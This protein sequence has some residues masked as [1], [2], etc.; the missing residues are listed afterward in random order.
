VDHGTAYDL[1]GTGRASALS[2]AA[3]IR[4]AV[5]MAKTAHGK[6]STKTKNQRSKKTKNEQ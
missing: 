2:M 5:E 3:A 4:M 6:N 1:A